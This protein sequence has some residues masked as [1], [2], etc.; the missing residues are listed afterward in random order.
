MATEFRCQTVDTEWVWF[1][2]HFATSITYVTQA[3]PRRRYE[4]GTGVS[5][6]W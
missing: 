5:F 4:I 1:S 2:D 3:A 6:W